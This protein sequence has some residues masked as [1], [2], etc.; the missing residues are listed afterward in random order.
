MSGSPAERGWIITNPPYGVRVGEAA[1][2]RDLY[3]RF[4]Q[5][6]TTRFSNWSI[7]MLSADQRL[8]GHTQ[9][10]LEE[11]WRSRTGGIP[12]RFLIRQSEVTL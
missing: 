6:A 7:G 4:G 10:Q 8:T 12:V 3:A 9:L 5:L 11:T 2:L 1:R